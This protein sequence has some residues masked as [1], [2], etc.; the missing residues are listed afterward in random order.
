MK[1]ITYR[2]YVNL[3]IK[4]RQR[5]SGMRINKSFETQ[6]GTVKFEGLLEKDE[7]DMVLSAGLNFLFLQ[8]A[9]PFKVAENISDVVPTS[10][11]LQ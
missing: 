9:L 6:E 8:G 3:V 4:L 11:T 2:Y 1:L 10:E 7:L 5:K